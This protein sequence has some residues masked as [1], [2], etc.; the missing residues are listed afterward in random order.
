MRHQPVG[1]GSE[2]LLQRT[3]VPLLVAAMPRSPRAARLLLA[4]PTAAVQ[5]QF[6]RPF[7]CMPLMLGQASKISLCLPLHPGMAPGPAA[8]CSF[9]LVLPGDPDWCPPHHPASQMEHGRVGGDRD[10]KKVRG[11]PGPPATMG[12]LVVMGWVGR[13]AAEGFDGPLRPSPS[14]FHPSLACRR[15]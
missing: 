8:C 9:V 4:S 15:A 14:P 11:Q 6:P 7:K 5:P 10:C 13:A 2:G 1:S 12:R 3:V